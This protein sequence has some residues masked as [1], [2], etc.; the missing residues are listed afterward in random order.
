MEKVQNRFTRRI[1]GMKNM[2]YDERLRRLGL[3]TLEERRNRADLIETINLYQVDT[4]PH[5]LFFELDKHS[6]NRGH[7]YKIVNNRFSKTVRQYCFSQSME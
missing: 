5:E 3:W 6:R 7:C 2:T 4:V 1:P